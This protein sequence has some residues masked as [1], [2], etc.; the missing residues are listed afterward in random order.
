MLFRLLRYVVFFFLAFKNQ[1]SNERF[2]EIDVERINIIE[3]DGTLK[4]VISNK[5][6]QHPGMVNHKNMKQRE[7]DAGLIFLIRWEMS[8]ADLYMMVIK[9]G[10]EW[11]IL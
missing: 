4:M 8:V 9:K 10:P 3:K 2:K 7:R 5:E 11:Y 1:Y 6:R